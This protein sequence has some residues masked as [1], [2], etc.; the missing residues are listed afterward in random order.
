MV[1]LVENS[2]LLDKHKL[3]YY[4]TGQGIPILFVHGITTY[5]FIWRKVVPYFVKDYRVIVVDLLG[6]GHSDL[7]TDISFGIANQA[8]FLWMLLDKL[9]IEKL[10]VV[11]HDVGGGVAQIMSVVRPGALLSVSLLN[12]VAYDFWPVQLLRP[13]VFLS[14]ASSQWPP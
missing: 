9:G 5:S 4:E 6:C 3:V 12:A 1:N 7:R 13:C 2:V 8:R 10:H 14:F 11:A